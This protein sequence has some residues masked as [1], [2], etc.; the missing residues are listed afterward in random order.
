[1]FCHTHGLWYDVKGQIRRHTS[2]H[3]HELCAG[4]RQVWRVPTSSLIL[5][6]R[7]VT[8]HKQQNCNTLIGN[9]T[10]LLHMT[11]LQQTFIVYVYVCVMP[12]QRCK[13]VWG[14]GC[15]H[16]TNL[17]DATDESTILEHNMYVRHPVSLSQGHWGKGR[18]T[19]VGDA[20]H[21]LRPAS[22]AFATALHCIVLHHNGSEAQHKARCST[23]L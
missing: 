22:G 1:M 20:A 19:L 2:L 6:T 21:P 16:V 15:K 4:V 23:V 11:R 8:Y 10:C 12:L 14:D 9:S 7:S 18:V 13:R 17:I 3:R 5:H